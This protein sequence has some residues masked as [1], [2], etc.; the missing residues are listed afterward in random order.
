MHKFRPDRWLDDDG[1]LRNIP[2]FLPF[3]L[4]RLAKADFTIVK[5]KV[6]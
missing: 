4:G 1:K 2:E 5:E 3:G 6:H